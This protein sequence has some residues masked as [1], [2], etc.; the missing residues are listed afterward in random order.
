[1]RRL[2]LTILLLFSTCVVAP[3]ADATLF[4]KEG[5]FG[6]VIVTEHNG[7]RTLQFERGGARQTVV[8]MGDPA[9]LELPYA[10]VALTGLS[11]CEAPRRVLIVG[12]GGGTLP[13][14]I[15]QYFPEAVIDGVDINPD[16]VDVA[17]RFLGFREDSRM[18]GIVADGRKFIEETR[19]PYDVIF[20]DAFGAD[21]VPPPLSTVEFL[22][23]VRK[24]LKPSGVAVGN[25]W[26]REYNRLYDPMV[27]TYQE[28]FDELYLLEVRGVGNRILL[29]LP[30]KENFTRTSLAARA[31]A[32]SRAKGFRFDMSSLVHSGFNHLV[33][34]D[35]SARVLTDAEMLKP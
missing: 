32:L 15:R 30:R 34:R 10:P 11:V 4:E 20:L 23:A 26:S 18:R 12:L 35:A 13:M 28:T 7:L 27:R 29:G 31:G 33:E 19:E 2:F 1:M 22:R 16:V 9:H 8:K 5:A 24:A 3:A 21:S 6:W 25:I 14:F 17:R